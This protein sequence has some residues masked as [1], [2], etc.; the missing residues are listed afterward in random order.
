VPT[1]RKNPLRCA[2]LTAL[3]LSILLGT[4][5]AAAA[6]QQPTSGPPQSATVV[7][8]PLTPEQDREL[9]EWLSAIDKWRRDELRW[10]N[11]PRR[12]GWER[13]TARRPPPDPPQ[14]LGAYCA[15]LSAAGVAELD[16][17]TTRGCRL[18]ADPRGG[19]DAASARTSAADAEKPQ[20]KSFFL[21]RVHLDGLWTTTSTQARVYGLVGSHV[22][23]V[24]VGRLHVFGP[25]GVLLL[26]VPDTVGSRRLTLGY[27]W[28]VSVR[29]ADIHVFDGKDMTLFLNVSKVWIDGGR[30][31]DIVGFSLAPRK[32]R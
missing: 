3:A 30:G 7:I 15:S 26:S 32:K 28:G 5:T 23:L 4:S 11:R 25:P 21:T 18:H 10:T 24:D 20:K 16:E 14:W 1:L 31:L 8:E 12:D 27:T 22:S 29:L 13:I 6:G 2:R 9:D 17:R 19:A